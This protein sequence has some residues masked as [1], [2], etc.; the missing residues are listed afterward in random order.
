MIVL[1]AVAALALFLIDQLNTTAKEMG[2]TL[3][4]TSNKIQSK[5]E[6]MVE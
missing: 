6:S 4:T 5:I 1:A 2:E 3:S